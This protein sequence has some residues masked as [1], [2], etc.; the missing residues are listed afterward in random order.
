MTTIAKLFMHDGDQAVCLPDDCCFECDEVWIGRDGDKVI[1]EPL[2]AQTIDP[3]QI[4][5]KLDEMGAK[6]FLADGIPD[7]PPAE[8]DPR[9]FFDE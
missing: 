6:D 4:W 8:P 2:K 7:D 1:L 3:E 9:K 5:A